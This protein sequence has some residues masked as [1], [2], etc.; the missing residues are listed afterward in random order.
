MSTTILTDQV[1]TPIGPMLLM[2]EE[3][4]IVGLEFGDQPQRYLRDL[5]HRFP[6]FAMR[7]QANPHGF[8]DCLRAYYSGDLSALD[9]LPV[10]GG[11]TP[12]QERVWAELRRITVG[13]T[14]SYGELAMRLGDSRAVRAVGLA[15]GRNPISVVVPCHRVIG[16]D[17]MLT[18][19]G[20]GLPRKAWLLSHEGVSVRNGQVDSQS[21]LFDPSTASAQ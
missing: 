9:D 10:R 20:G 11:G 7:E 8:S 12:F 18:G 2:V 21:D 5:R 4:V 13:T 3:D 1:E 15:N 6:D 14:V 19:Y 16:S 17:G